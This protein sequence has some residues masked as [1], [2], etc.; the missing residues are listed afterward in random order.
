MAL[1]EPK[2][3]VAAQLSTT[4]WQGPKKDWHLRPLCNLRQ[5][6]EVADSVHMRRTQEKHLKRM[7]KHLNLRRRP[8]SWRART[9]A[10]PSRHYGGVTKAG[11]PY[12]M[13]AGS[14]TNY[15]VHTVQCR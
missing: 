15:T 6:L 1:E 3:A 10:P 5:N 9:A 13:P 12:A 14:T 8:C 4:D 11:T 2:D 7:A